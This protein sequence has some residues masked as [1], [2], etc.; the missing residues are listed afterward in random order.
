MEVDLCLLL[1]GGSP[2]AGGELSN[3]LDS[4]LSN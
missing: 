2:Y 4:L 1:E 3:W